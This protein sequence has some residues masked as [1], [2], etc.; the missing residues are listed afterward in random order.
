M[1]REIEI[2]YLLD[3]KQDVNKLVEKLK[4]V[5]P[6][7]KR[8]QQS[9]VISYFYEKPNSIEQVLN[10]ARNIIS[11]SKFV[12]LQNI[13]KENM[14]LIVKARS[15]DKDVFFAVKVAAEGEDAVHAVNR[16][17]FEEKIDLSL[18]DAN[19]ILIN[20]GVSL[21]SKWYSE[22]DF[23]KITDDMDMNIEFVSGY[24][25]KAEIEIL[26]ENSQSHDA[27][28]E[29]RELALSLDLE[30]ASQELLGKMY[31]YYNQHWREYFKKEKVFTGEVWESLGRN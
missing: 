24:G 11:K 3:D 28:L 31:E 16:L 12:E 27:E 14:D 13:L 25:Y 5:H 8:T 30:E 7:A 18:E 20:N 9:T 26:T 22:R 29:I 23:Y 4:S 6:K 17:E 15:I 21:A 10:A 1:K 19:Q 2:K